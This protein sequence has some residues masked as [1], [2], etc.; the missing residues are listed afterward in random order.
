MKRTNNYLASSGYGYVV[1]FVLD[2]PLFDHGQAQ[3]EQATAQRALVAARVEALS[4]SVDAEVQSALFARRAAREELLRFEAQTSAQV[5]ALLTAAQSGYREGERAIIELLD[6]QRAQTEVAE[7]RLSLLGA[8]KR[9]E[10][11][12]R[13]AVGEFQ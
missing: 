11:K 3:R 13:A 7:Q 9:A 12:L 2:I 6:A 4:R 10:A 1:G 8:A 5:D